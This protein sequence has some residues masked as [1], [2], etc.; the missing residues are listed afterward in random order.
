MDEGGEALAM[1]HNNQ[2]V[3]GRGER[4]MEE[5]IEGGDH[6]DNN[7]TRALAAMVSAEKG[8][9]SNGGCHHQLCGNMAAVNGGSG[10]GG[11][12]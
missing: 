3:N 6:K 9:G 5:E 10:N 2:I 12:C 7:D 8:G 11:R 4:E 1:A